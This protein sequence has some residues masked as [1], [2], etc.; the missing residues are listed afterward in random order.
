[1]TAED[2]GSP[3]AAADPQRPTAAELAAQTGLSPQ[4]IDRFVALGLIAGADGDGRHDPG[5]VSRL[6]LLTALLDSGIDADRLAAAVS[7]RRLSLEFAGSILAEPVRLAA[8]T[9]E[10]ARAEV[11]IA[12][13]ELPRLMASLGLPAPAADAPIREDDLEFMRIYA[14]ARDLGIPDQVILDT[15]RSFAISMRRLV[16][17]AR[18]LVR[19]HVE[20]RLLASG[21]AYR[22]M[23]DTAAR[24]RVTLQRTAYRATYLIQRRLFEQAVWQNMIARF[25]EA[26][27][28]DALA[29]RN[30]GI[31]GTICFVDLS[32]FTRRT[33][34]L[35]DAHAAN[36]GSAL[37]DIAN[38]EAT[39]HHGDLVKPLGDGAMLHFRRADEAVRCARAIL[40]LAAR[41]GLPPA[42]AGI[43]SGP[44]IT[45]GGDYYGRTVNR[46]ARLLG[47]AEPGR[48]LVTAEIAGAIAGPRVRFTDLGVVKLKGVDE[49]VHAFAVAEA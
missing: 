31:S 27:A 36:L 12:D 33:E 48:I 49:E 16:E 2:T 13:D 43:A 8:I 14:T 6:R 38:S 40:S 26:L 46:A 47:I 24:I 9:P 28:D 41:A 44:V 1:M 30:A 34:S 3:A 23:F 11:G 32:D 21:M 18:E 5:D 45:H 10:Q 35:G 17:A 29:L 4:A 25:E 15:L 22:D 39:R 37:I 42:R 19:E 20:D 7:E